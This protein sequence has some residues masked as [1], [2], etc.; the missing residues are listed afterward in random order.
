MKSLRSTKFIV[1]I[2]SVALLVAGI[3]GISASA[4]DAP[5]LEIYSKNLSYGG[6]I[7]I[8]FAV[9]AQN[10]DADAVELLIYTSEPTDGAV[11]DY[12]VSTSTAATVHEREALVFLTPGIA[13]KDMTKQIY[14]KA[15]AVVNGADVYSETER[16]SVAEYAYDMQYRSKI[17]DNF[18]RLGAALLEVGEQI[19]T[20][21][22]YNEDN[23]PS[24]F[25]YVAAEGGTVDGKY[26]A[27][28]F[29]KG[30]TVT[31]N[32]TG[33]IPEGKIAIWNSEA[34]SV[35]NGATVKASAHAVYTVEFKNGYVPG[36]YY[37]DETK[38]G[39]RYDDVKSAVG[40][41][42]LLGIENNALSSFE[43]GTTYIV[44]TDF[45]YNGGAYKSNSPA[46]FGLL[47][48]G[49]V[50][51]KNMFL[52]TYIYQNDKS[53]NSVSIFGYEFLKGTT[54]N[55]RMEYTVGDGDYMIGGENDAFAS[56]DEYL[57][58]GL[59]FFVN[60][61]EVDVSNMEQQLMT[62]ENLRDNTGA[63]ASFYGL[64][65]KVRNSSYASADFS[66]SFDNTFI[67]PKVEIEQ[68]ES[69]KGYYANTDIEGTRLD[70]SDASDLDC[71]AQDNSHPSNN[72]Y[73]SA[74]IVNGALNVSGNPA[75]YGLLFETPAFDASKTYAQ[76]TKYVF[77][78]DITYNGGASASGDKNAAFTGF[79][80]CDYGSDIRNG[81][82]ATF[83]YTKYE[84]SDA[85]IDIYG[86]DFKKGETH[87]L[88]IVYTVGTKITCEVYLDL[89]KISDAALST[90]SGVA[91]TNCA[92]FGFYFRGTGYTKDLDLTFD[93]VFVGVIEAE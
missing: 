42:A 5:T 70:F 66:V 83:S 8:A 20:L 84:N 19:Q 12:T 11:A 91:D 39:T 56:R 34:G 77:E 60:G 49:S 75:W 52:F 78:A 23:S 44:E 24:D 63:D 29:K 76:G 48:N 59:K 46:F 58:K 31:L 51:N 61:T 38:V 28:L 4:D 57:R 82:M 14:V 21:L 6:T 40:S 79:I 55:I 37:N 69:F 93:N 43:E 68:D 30:E 62:G 53:A 26:S 73:G 41:G 36:A 7:S 33:E 89:V 32:Y 72:N 92:G 10:V 80:T 65:V 88:T 50:D 3:I 27:G 87:K 85:N 47:A 81:D 16:Y 86:A 18:V 1:L 71:V 35:A 67:A 45:T 2:I 54:Y 15:H 17:N 13:A 22:P 74:S 64:G 90:T 9:D 25:Y